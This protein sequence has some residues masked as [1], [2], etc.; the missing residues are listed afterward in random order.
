M[1]ARREGDLLQTHMLAVPNSS[2]D[3]GVKTGASSWS[4]SELSLESE[5]PAMFYYIF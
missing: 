1:S 3:S 2:F 4:S 5:S